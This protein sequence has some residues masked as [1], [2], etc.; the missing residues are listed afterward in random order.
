MSDPK[1]L[2]GRR[3]VCRQCRSEIRWAKTLAGVNGRGGKSMP[4]DP[5]PNPEGNVAVRAIA[6]GRLVARVLGKGETHD[7]FTEQRAMPHFATCL[8]SE[9]ND[10]IAGV[11]SLLA[12]AVIDREQ[13]TTS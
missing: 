3:D 12:D 7:T 13:E 2:P 6:S 10:L 1:P 11:E 5:Y 4:L 8:K 9:T